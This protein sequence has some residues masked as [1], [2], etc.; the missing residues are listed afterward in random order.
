MP[1]CNHARYLEKAIRSC[2]EQSYS[3]SEVWVID[4]ASPDETPEI[5]KALCAQF[6]AIRYHRH[7]SNHGIVAN[8]DFAFRQPET[9]FIVKLDSDDILKPRY[10][11]V[12][13]AM[14]LR[15]PDAGYA[16]AAVEQIDAEGSVTTLRRL[17]R[18]TGYVD[19]QEA[20]RECLRGGKYA[21]NIQMFRR[22]ALSAVDYLRDAPVSA[23]DYYLSVK[24]ADAGYGNVYSDELLA[25]YR[26]WG[27][28]QWTDKRVVEEIVGLIHTFNR[29][30]EP[31]YE[32]RRWALGRV[33]RFRKLRALGQ[34]TLLAKTYL[35]PAQRSQ[36][37]DLVL[38]LSSHPLVRLHV[39]MY[40]HG[41][42]AYLVELT[43]V[44]SRLRK[45]IKEIALHAGVQRI[46]K[47]GLHHEE[48]PL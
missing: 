1:T 27:G 14:L 24:L 10:V 2:F 22:K 36:V 25:Q 38:Q 5:M 23:E 16:H 42:G 41:Y 37:T 3:V 15:Y 48:K 4:D 29:A 28:T 33:A 17:F 30:I 31:A 32:R 20:L 8:T 26:V 21:A 35:S 44:S 7:A 47:P 46:V 43:S 39:W 18:N 9:D 12:L 11:E 45:Y 19:P 6:P 34:A 13:S 40:N